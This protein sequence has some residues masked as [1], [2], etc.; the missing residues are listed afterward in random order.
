MDSSHQRPK[1]RKAA[2]S[3]PQEARPGRFKTL[4]FTNRRG[5]KMFLEISLT[6]TCEELKEGKRAR[7][8]GKLSK[9]AF[10]DLSETTQ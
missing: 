1:Q 2:G 10:I 5:Y 7:R 4:L 6:H 8:E 3:P 9:A